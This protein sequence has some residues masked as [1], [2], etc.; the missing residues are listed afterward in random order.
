MPLFGRS[1][2]TPEFVMTDSGWQ[3]LDDVM[4]HAWSQVAAAAWE[5]YQSSGRGLVSLWFNPQ[6]MQYVTIADAVSQ[7]GDD[8]KSVAIRRDGSRYRP[9]REVL[10]MVGGC[11]NVAK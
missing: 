8:P 4:A 2:G 6:R 10:A 7:L 5:G 3:R 1:H 9:D 11:A